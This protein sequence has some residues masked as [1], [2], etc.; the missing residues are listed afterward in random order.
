MAVGF[1]HLRHNLPRLGLLGPLPSHLLGRPPLRSHTLFIHGHFNNTIAAV[2]V[3]H[4][5]AVLYASV[6]FV[7]VAC[8]LAGLAH[9]L[10]LECSILLLRCL[11]C[12]RRLHPRFLVRLQS[13]L[14]LHLCFAGPSEFSPRLQHLES[15]ILP[16]LHLQL[17]ASW[18]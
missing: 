1:V 7:V 8:D 16:H 12:L 15:Q 10:H 3:C 9:P 4:R 11:L 18:L 5:H 13:S 6:A 14:L 2:L 17:A